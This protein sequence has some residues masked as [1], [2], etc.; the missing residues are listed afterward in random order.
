MGLCGETIR[1]MAKCEESSLHPAERSITISGGQ[2]W[3]S[4]PWRLP[5]V[6]KELGKRQVVLDHLLKSR[7][8][9]RGMQ[10]F[11]SHAPQEMLGTGELSLTCSQLSS[12]LA[13]SGNSSADTTVIPIRCT[14]NAKQAKPLSCS[15]CKALCLSAPP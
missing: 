3:G 9:G 2:R 15:H 4:K 7:L 11:L 14:L 8:G 1:D 5:Y 13:Q 10:A 6:A 12:S